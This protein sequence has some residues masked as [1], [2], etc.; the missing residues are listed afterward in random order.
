MKKGENFLRK[1]RKFLWKVLELFS[2]E[3]KKSFLFFNKKKRKNQIKTLK[4]KKKKKEKKKME[5]QMTSLQF[6]EKGKGKYGIAFPTEFT[7]GSTKTQI[8]AGKE[9]MKYFYLARNAAAVEK[10]KEAW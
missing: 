8:E 3:R 7:G 6:R 2:C 1:K 5:S 9:A 10:D 4:N